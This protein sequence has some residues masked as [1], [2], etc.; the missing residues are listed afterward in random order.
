VGTTVLGYYGTRYKGTQFLDCY[1]TNNEIFMCA[2]FNDIGR[3]NN[4]KLVILLLEC[5][6]LQV[7]LGAITVILG[8]DAQALGGSGNDLFGTIFP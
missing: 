6:H 7:E 1:Y 4:W 5:T 2:I 8:S 3:F